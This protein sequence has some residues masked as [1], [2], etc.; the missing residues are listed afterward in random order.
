[1][2]QNPRPEAAVGLLAGGNGRLAVVG[3]VA[4]VGGVGAV[5]LGAAGAGA[6]HL[7][8]E[9]EVVLVFAGVVLVIRAD[10]AGLLGALLFFVIGL[11]DGALDH[12]AAGRVD[13]VGDVGVQLGAA[14]GVA[15]G[16]VLVELGTA[17]V[18]VPG[19]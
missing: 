13:R 15:D 17:L 7:T 6:A 18:A 8:E 10:V 14:V 9:R 16:P 1:M 3:G 19:A 12:L 4:A 5:A 11:E 2:L